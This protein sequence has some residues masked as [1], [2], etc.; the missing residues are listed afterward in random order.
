MVAYEIK[1]PE[2]LKTLNIAAAYVRARARYLGEAMDKSVATTKARV[3]GKIPIGVTGEARSS[4]TTT[5]VR[6]PYQMV[7]KISSSMRR[8]NVYIFVLNAGVR[9]GQGKQPPSDRLVPW[10]VQ[11]GLARDSK[12]AKK[13]AYLIA[14]SIKR[15]GIKS[16][17][18]QWRG[19]SESEAA[20]DAYHKQAVDAIVQ[21][22][23][24]N[25]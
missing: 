10:V 5:I 22:L 11:K 13:V 24:K 3:Q 15:K 16:L 17:S 4:I 1:I 21:E 23:D 9:P 2:K 25:A 8:P 19:L 12:D 18:F 20:I 6:T 7:G 14:R